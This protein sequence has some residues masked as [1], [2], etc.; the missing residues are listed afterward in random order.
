MITKQSTNFREVISTGER[1]SLMLRFLA[2]GKLQQSL[3]FADR[4][5]NTTVSNIIKKT[6]DA[7]FEK[8]AP[9]YL[10]TPSCEEEWLKLANDFEELWNFPNMIGALDCKHIRIQCPAGTGTKLHN[11][12]GFFSLVLLCCLRCKILLHSY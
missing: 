1:L 8:L 10:T 12:K 6:C 9:I 4:V 7:I 11:Y 2:S 3:P 5:G